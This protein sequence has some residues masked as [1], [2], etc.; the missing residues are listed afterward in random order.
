MVVSTGTSFLH[1]ETVLLQAGEASPSFKIHRKLLGFKCKS[2]ISAFEGGF[3][4]D[5]KGKKKGT[6]TFQDTSE[7][8]LARFIHGYTQGVSQIFKIWPLKR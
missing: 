1:S 6:Y 4:E 5:Q 8:T 2:I 3:E 7:G